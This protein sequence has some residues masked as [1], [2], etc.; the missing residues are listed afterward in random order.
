[1]EHELPSVEEETAEREMTYQRMQRARFMRLE[2]VR[3]FGMITSD[4]FE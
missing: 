3:T 2:H 1:M 4:A